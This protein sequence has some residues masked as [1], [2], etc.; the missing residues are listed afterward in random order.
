MVVEIAGVKLSNAE[1]VV[2]PALG[3]TKAE[4][5]EYY[6]A[7]G[8]WVM[9]HVKGRPLTLVRCPEGLAKACFYMKHS[10]TWAPPSLRRV[11]IQEKT[12]VGEYLVVDDLAGVISLAQMG[13]LEIHTWNSPDRAVETPNR[14]VFDLDPDPSVAWDKVIAAALEVRIRLEELGLQ[15][16]V[17]TTGGK[18]LHVVMP[19][20]KGGGWGETLA[21]SRAVAE[22]MEHDTPRAYTTAMPK[23]ARK[24]KILVDYLRN[25]R[26]STSVAAYSTRAR[27]E[28]T[29]SVPITWE[30]LPKIRPDELTLKTVPARL[31]RLR[32]DPWAEYWTSKQ[33]LSA[34]LKKAY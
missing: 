2:Y 11:N 27:A 31:A 26:G 7:V 28:A 17:K 12:K 13:V 24:G 3:I 10:G 30:E 34:K 6:Q 15:S 18:G 5:A 16:F 23:A 20:P 8:D 33:R 14:I 22:Q 9:P 32:K 25:N 1:R 4:V 21:F 19:L 29:V